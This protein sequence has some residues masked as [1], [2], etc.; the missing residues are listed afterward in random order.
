MKLPHGDALMILFKNLSH[1]SI[2]DTNRRGIAYRNVEVRLRQE[3]GRTGCPQDVG[4]RLPD[5]PPPE[6]LGLPRSRA[7]L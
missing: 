4:V 2:T 6:E 3:T 7:A 1:K 5:R